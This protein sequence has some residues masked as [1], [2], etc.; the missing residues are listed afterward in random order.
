[1]KQLNIFDYEY[2]VLRKVLDTLEAVK[3]ANRSAYQGNVY[4]KM[5]FDTA[6]KVIGHE[7]E[8]GEKNDT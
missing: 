3:I 7:L 5:G 1:M 6:E 4:W 2:D 8:R